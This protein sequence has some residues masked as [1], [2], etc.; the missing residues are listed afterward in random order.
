MVVK[1][2]ILGRPGS[3]KS[4]AVEHIEELAWHEGWSYLSICDYNIL[5]RMFMREQRKP[6]ALWR[7]FESTEHNGFK[8]KDFSVLDPALKIVERRVRKALAKYQMQMPELVIIEF[9]RNNYSQAF[10]QFS[11][12]FLR[13]AYFLFIEADIETCI[14]RIRVGIDD[15]QSKGIHFVSNDIITGYY[16]TDCKPYFL[17]D[18]STDF[19]IPLDTIRVIEN[20][21]H[22]DAFLEKIHQFGENMLKR[23]R[24]NL[25]QKRLSIG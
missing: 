1:L 19:D 23:E 21:S 12:D 6:E 13:D 10:M 4:T 25:S 14:R 15:H 9:A 3:G 5:H 20:T 17:S 22:Y 7:Q 8:V 24:N 16:G 2:F 18:M 11:R